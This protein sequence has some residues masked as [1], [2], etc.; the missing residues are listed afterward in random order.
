MVKS[1]TR[2]ASYCIL[3]SGQFVLANTLTPNTIYY[4]GSFQFMVFSGDPD[5]DAI[6][7]VR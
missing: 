5:A 6:L 4:N 3:T 7:I 1:S 2:P